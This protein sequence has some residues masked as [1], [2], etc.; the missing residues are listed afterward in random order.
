LATILIIDDDKFTRQV[1]CKILRRDKTIAEFK[2][3]IVEASN[4]MEGL[5]LFDV[6][7]PTL[8]IV[9]LLMPKMDGFEVCKR[10][11]DQAPKSELT[12]AV[13]SGVYKDDAISKRIHDEFQAE[14]FAKPYQIKKIASFVAN[15]L[16]PD[17]AEAAPD[18]DES[19]KEDTAS[20]LSGSLKKRSSAKLL[21]DFLEQ[22]KSG[23]LMLRRG[24]V[25]RQIEL[26]V[27]HPVS[28][29]TNV[30]EETLGHF[31]VAK[32]RINSETHRVAMNLAS[33]N[34]VRFGEAIIEMG[35]LTANDLIME[36]TA[37][38]RY[39]LVNSLRWRDGNWT[40]R[41]GEPRNSNSNALNV[42]EVIVSG[43]AATAQLEP[44]P[45]SLSALREKALKLNSRGQKLLA[46]ISS[47]V[48]PSFAKHFTSGTTIEA[49][50]HAGVNHVEIF[51]CLDVL[52][53]CDG[54][55]VTLPVG[56]PTHVANETS[57][58]FKLKSIAHARVHHGEKPDLIDSLFDNQ[59]AQNTMTGKSPLTELGSV[60][61]W[62]SL[63]STSPEPE[64]EGIADTIEGDEP[65]ADE[66]A[67]EE[68]RRRRRSSLVKAQA[69]ASDSVVDVN[70]SEPAE[71]EE[72]SSGRGAI[73]SEFL[74]IQ[75]KSLYAVL[76]VPES[77]TEDDIKT[78]HDRIVGE[79]EKGQFSKLNLG[80][81]FQK[82]DVLHATYNRSLETLLDKEKRA[83]YDKS[84]QST[85]EYLSAP[86]SMDAEI[87]FR[88]GERL[89]TVGDNTGAMEKLKEAVTIAP[90][91]AAYKAELGW[92]I[93]LQGKKEA[94]AADEAR[95]Y[96][97]DALAMAP[98]DAMANEYKGLIDAHLGDDIDTALLHLEK[99][100]RGDP[101]RV[102]SLRKVEELRIERGEYHAL[103]QLYRRLLFGLKGTSNE[104]EALVWGRLGDLHRH[105]LNDDES[106]L[107]AFEAA[108]KLTP[109]DEAL[110][111]KVE[112]LKGGDRA[113]Y[114]GLNR[115]IVSR[116]Q[117]DPT[118][119]APLVELLNLARNTEHHDG[120]FLAASGLLAAGA[121]TEEIEKNYKRHRPRYLQRAQ[122]TLEPESWSYAL[123]PDDYE[124]L[125]ALYALLATR[126]QK[127]SPPKDAEEEI[128]RATEVKDS[129]LP[130]SFHSVRSYV[131][132]VL[133][134]DEPAIFT[135]ESYGRT[136]HVAALAT[137]VLM[138]GK[139]T[140]ECTDK[141]ELAFRLGRAMSFLRPGRAVAASCPSSILKSAMLA[142]YAL[143]SPNATV[144]DPDGNVA[145]IKATIKRRDDMLR[146]QLTELV[147][148]ISQEHPSLNLS[149]WVRTLNRTADRVGLL[150]CGDLPTALRCLSETS[151]QDASNHLIAFA[152]SASHIQLRHMMGLSIEV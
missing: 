1:L 106:A 93:F 147:S 30:R 5:R 97:N 53:Q 102:E 129:A 113:Q 111:D 136:I 67:P 40:F 56:V 73:I 14:F 11:R 70:F 52:L 127:V 2:P 99:A 139:Q 86:P 19:S 142:C 44:T 23:R 118:N 90:T 26:Y 143:R 9:D 57:D 36:L 29:T 128:A 96:I 122:R 98:D 114:Y 42:V 109:L 55:V 101:R 75:E 39:K 59:A 119:T 60:E 79:F 12:I 18:E 58:T 45:P 63:R 116:W 84:L 144:P 35:V 149:R 87:A 3:T 47:S 131:A 27:G 104:E 89:L 130:A 62:K 51:A 7:K 65:E 115:D 107:I 21:L 32:K 145:A 112:E 33:K 64:P 110:Q 83:R 20:A 38:T 74:R 134:V 92:T 13:T 49:L 94:R 135:H 141:L 80:R 43:L 77:A 15:V 31:L 140:L 121:A 41:P 61:L 48:S 103:Q 28:V 138:V 22:E 8:A 78:A 95:T 34:R 54:L 150:L 152:V 125:G 82:L 137:P 146:H 68:R 108:L 24:Q 72:L 124:L 71:A 66:S 37:Q 132:H 148:H 151:D 85:D 133:G 123:F 91:E 25:V 4:G 46:Q 120:A 126:I 76:K 17:R 105:Y 69:L 50:E 100:L 10:L 81:D 16:S 6:H 117:A 88:E